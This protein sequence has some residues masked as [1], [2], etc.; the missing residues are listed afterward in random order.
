METTRSRTSLCRGGYVGLGALFGAG[1][2][3]VMAMYA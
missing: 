2:A 1:A 3:I